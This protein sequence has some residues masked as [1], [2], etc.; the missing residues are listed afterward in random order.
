MLKKDLA[1][2]KHRSTICTKTKPNLKRCQDKSMS[3]DI[4]PF[5][6]MFLC[7]LL[8]HKEASHFLK[9]LLKQQKL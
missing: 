2:L 7:L 1:L 8:K 6:E 4:F 3:L 9:L 5:L